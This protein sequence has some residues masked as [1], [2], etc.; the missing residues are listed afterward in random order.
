MGR[1]HRT[2]H[3]QRATA[4]FFWIDTPG[5]IRPIGKDYNMDV[6]PFIVENSTVVP[7][8]LVSNALGVDIG[9]DN[10]TRTVSIDSS[11]E[12]AVTPFYDM[13]I[14]SVSPGRVITGEAELA[15]AFPGGVP[16][17]A[18]EFKYLLIYPA[19]GRGAVV[20]RGSDVT[21]RYTWSI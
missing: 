3:I 15:A 8:R 2:V 12:A 4:R 13:Y 18:S 1:P 16:A 9:W 5:G 17:G 19:T 14:T 21:G 10:S 20:A 11:K 6:A 7:L